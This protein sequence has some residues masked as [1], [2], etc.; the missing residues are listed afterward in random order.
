MIT[1]DGVSNLIKDENGNELLIFAGVASAVNEAT[2]ANAATG[3]GP[4]LAA[5]G[6]DTNIPIT[7]KGK[8]TGKVILGQATSAGVQL[9][10]DQPLVDSAGNELLKFTGTASAVNEVTVANAAAAGT[11]KISA[12]GDDTNISLA[13]AP[14]GTG[15][16]SFEGAISSPVTTVQNLTNSA[17]ITL[18]TGGRN[19]RLSASGGAVTGIILTAGSYDGQEVVLWNIETTNTITFATGATSNVADGTSAVIGALRA[20]KFFWDATSARWFRSG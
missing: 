17:T 18:P 7:L 6:G 19:K 9:A 13:F 5:T 4:S 12:T 14:K 10:A 1:I 2:L 8:G 20:V 16:L 3:F 15:R 11:P